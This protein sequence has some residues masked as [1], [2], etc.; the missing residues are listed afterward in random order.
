MTRGEKMEYEHV[1]ES[2]KVEDDVSVCGG[3]RI[4]LAHGRGLIR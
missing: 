4:S 1:W 3:Y 2:K